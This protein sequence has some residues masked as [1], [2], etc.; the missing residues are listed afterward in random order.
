[1]EKV[2]SFFKTFAIIFYLKKL[3]LMK[4]LFGSVKVK[5]GVAARY[6][7]LRPTRQR[8]RP[9]LRHRPRATHECHGRAVVDLPSRAG[10]AGTLLKVS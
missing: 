1:M 7:G 8:P 9:L 5:S 4:V 2:V 6:S 3:E 10:R